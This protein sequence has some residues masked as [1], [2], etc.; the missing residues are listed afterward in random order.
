MSNRSVMAG[1]RRT[2]VWP[3]T[4]AS[5]EDVAGLD[6]VGILVAPDGTETVHPAVVTQGDTPNVGTIAVTVTF[7]DDTPGGPH[8]LRLDV[9][10]A[11]GDLAADQP[12]FYVTAAAAQRP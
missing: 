4:L 5:G 12:R 9:N 6:A 1:S 8:T 10:D 2:W 3:V 11:S 7:P